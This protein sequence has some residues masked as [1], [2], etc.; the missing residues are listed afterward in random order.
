MAGTDD[1]DAS[2]DTASVYDI[3]QDV[4]ENKR[5]KLLIALTAAIGDR[6][7][8]KFQILES[9]TTRVRKPS[10]PIK[11]PIDYVEVETTRTAQ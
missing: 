8:S 1:P 10:V 4:C 11:G 2:V 9:V 5:F 7:L 6:I 3:V